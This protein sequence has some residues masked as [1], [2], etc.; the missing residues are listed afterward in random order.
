[1]ASRTHQPNKQV[2]MITS[3]WITAENIGSFL[4]AVGGGAAYDRLMTKDI[5]QISVHLLLYLFS[6]G[7]SDSCLL[8]SL[9][10]LLG[11][12]LIIGF[13]LLS[14]C[15]N[16]K[17]RYFPCFNCYLPKFNVKALFWEVKEK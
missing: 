9:M 17:F 10:Q 8:V 6:V 12:A 11:V 3:L 4:G 16:S 5:S 13:I 15:S 7:W 2:A 1:M 14:C